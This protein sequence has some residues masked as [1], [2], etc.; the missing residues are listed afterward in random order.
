MAQRTL[1]APRAPTVTPA[2]LGGILW[3][4]TAAVNPARGPVL[5]VYENVL[6]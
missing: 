5:L 1:P 2:R 3:R 6:P 4:H